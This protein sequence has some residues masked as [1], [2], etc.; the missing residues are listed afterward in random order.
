MLLK[1]LNTLYIY[2]CD[3]HSF[4]IR[5]SKIELS[6]KCSCECYSLKCS[7]LFYILKLGTLLVLLRK[8]CYFELQF[9]TLL[10]RE[11]IKQSIMD[12]CQWKCLNKTLEYIMSEF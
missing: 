11:L 7:F 8:C 3:I 1:Y 5:T 6:L 9:H 2:Y 4:F 10:F 12:G